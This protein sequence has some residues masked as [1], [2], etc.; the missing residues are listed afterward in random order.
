MTTYHIIGAGIAGASIAYHLLQLNQKVFIYDRDDI[1]QATKASAGIICPWTSQRRNKKWYRLVK[2]GAKYYP[3]FIDELEALTDMQTGYR[4]RGALCLFKDDY[5][6]GLAYER[7]KAKQ[8]E[9]PEMGKVLKLTAEELTTYHPSMTT[10]YPAVYVE[11][12]AQVNGFSLL[13]ALK[14]AIIQLGGQWHTQS[15]NPQ[16]LDG[17]IIYTAGAWSN[18]YAATPQVRHQR[19]ELLEVMLHE[20]PL[21]DVA[22]VVMGLG[23]MYIVPTTKNHYMIGTT[24]ED[25]TSFNMNDSPENRDYL[26]TQIKRYFKETPLKK[27]ISSIGFRPLTDENLPYIGPSGQLFVVNGLGSSGLTAAPVIGREVA[28]YL[29]GKKTV[30]DLTDYH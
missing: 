13:T 29:T 18:E 8:K 2:E 12:G 5:I 14:Q 11:G 16:T 21:A 15:V 27:G 26:F 6:Q 1:G 9:A 7:I 28:H 19:A 4:Q 3:Q 22:P 30:L 10:E 25:T 24:H 23:P 20:A 17:T